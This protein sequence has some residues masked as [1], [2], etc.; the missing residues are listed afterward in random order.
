MSKNEMLFPNHSTVYG[1]VKS[2]RF[3][4]SLGIDPIFKI[5]TCSFDCIYCQLGKIQVVTNQ[6]QVFVSAEQLE[7]DLIEFKKNNSDKID[8]ITFSGSGEPTLASNLAELASMVLK[9][10]PHTPLNI[11]TNAT[12]LLR[13]QVRQALKLFSKVTAKVDAANQEQFELVNRPAPGITLAG[14]IDGITHLQKEY[15]GEL[16]IQSM[17]MPINM[18]NLDQFVAI[19]KAIKPAALQLN[20]PSRPYPLSWHRE[21]RGNHLGIF[22]Y[23]VREL[24]KLD[25][26][27]A[28]SLEQILKSHLNIPIYS[29]YKKEQV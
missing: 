1:P 14:I 27:E 28:G 12:E 15:Q 9:H 29:I 13:P 19:I 20:T 5:S 23:D 11:L 7:Q 22:D 18:K 21:N 8:V 16:E 24:K 25:A 2:W 3:G 4:N 6:P 17:F 26:T 10:F